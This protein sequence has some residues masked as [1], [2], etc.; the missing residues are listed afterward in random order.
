[1]PSQLAQ[2]GAIQLAPPERYMSEEPTY[3]GASSDIGSSMAK[4]NG[5]ETT[6]V[7]PTLIMRRRFARHACVYIRAA[8]GL[9]NH[10]K[11]RTRQCLRNIASRLQH[12]NVLDGDLSLYS[13]LN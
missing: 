9:L 12:L 3:G 8:D 6:L 10:N 11:L 2:D 1:M 5:M 4:L 7:F 13:R